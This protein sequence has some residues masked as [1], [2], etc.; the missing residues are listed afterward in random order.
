MSLLHS[1]AAILLFAAQGASAGPVLHSH[2][3][4]KRTTTSQNVG[5]GFAIAICIIILAIVFYYLGMRHERTRSWF[6]S[7]NS[8]ITTPKSI[9]DDN[10][11]LQPHKFKAWISCPQN[12]RSSAPIKPYDDP[13][14]APAPSL[15]YYELPIKEIHEMGLP[16][17]RKPP[18]RAS[19]LSLDR[20]PWWLR[21]PEGEE[22][23]R[24]ASASAN[25]SVSVS[26]SASRG[27][28]R[29]KSLRSWFRSE[30]SVGDIQEEVPK[31]S[32]TLIEA[33]HLEVRSEK[34]EEKERKSDGSTLMDWSGLDHVKRIY[35]ARKSKA[36]L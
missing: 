32:P 12:V 36:G 20:K 27:T 31:L 21:Y 26:V 24:S 17:P 10:A 6:R 9:E 25:A 11:S 35:I 8:P 29:S 22:Q 19:W 34:E 3:L 30:R 7:S 14:E 15:R 2:I 28:S 5:S 1:F 16:S 18:P 4:A 33:V 13:V 23:R